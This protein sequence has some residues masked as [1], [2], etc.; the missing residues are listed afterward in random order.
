MH[1]HRFETN[2]SDHLLTSLTVFLEKNPFDPFCAFSP[3]EFESLQFLRVLKIFLT[4]P[5]TNRILNLPAFLE[6]PFC[7]SPPIESA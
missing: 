3:V 7:I 1:R 4:F 6:K 2:K 5:L